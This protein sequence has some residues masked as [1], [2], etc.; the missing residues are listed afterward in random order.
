MVKGLDKFIRQFSDF[1]EHFVLI[2]GTACYLNLHHMGATFRAT[3]D[4]DI[5]L[6]A[7]DMQN[8]MI[9]K[10]RDFLDAGGYLERQQDKESRRGYRFTKPS[11][12]DYPQMVELF[13]RRP[14]ILLIPEDQS[15]GPFLIDA[16]FTSL[17]AILMDDAYYALIR[18]NKSIIDECP[19][20]KPAALIVL[21]ARAWMDLKQRRR[22]G[23]HIDEH[24]VKKHRNDV[25]RLFPLLSEEMRVPLG[26]RIKEDFI[27]FCELVI[28]DPPNPADFGVRRSI[29]EIVGI[30]R[31]ICQ[32]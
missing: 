16:E 32:V 13:S 19:V 7:E 26:E 12:D 18:E 2:G 1:Q 4:L 11:V 9:G 30:L 14:D 8:E 5:V 6:F 28:E 3:K 22:Q 20:I 10:L 23:E 21:K 25:I 15:I 29:D 27:R 17:S 24:D 31:S